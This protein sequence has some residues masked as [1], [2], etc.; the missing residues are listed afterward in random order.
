MIK[1][2]VTLTYKAGN[3]VVFESTGSV[4][5]NQAAIEIMLRSNQASFDAQAA[6]PITLVHTTYHVATGIPECW[7]ETDELAVFARYDYEKTDWCM[8]SHFRPADSSLPRDQEFEDA[9]SEAIFASFERY[10][11]KWTAEAAESSGED[12]MPHLDP[13]I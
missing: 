6:L 3:G 9:M 8:S 10:K 7:F 2:N 4:D 5:M 12:G 11:D 13:D 1:V